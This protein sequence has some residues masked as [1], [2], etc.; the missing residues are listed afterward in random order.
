[1]KRPSKDIIENRKYSLEIRLLMF[2]V[3]IE[4][5]WALINGVLSVVIGMPK[6]TTIMYLILAIFNPVYYFLAEVTGFEKVFINAYF[7][8][9]LLRTPVMWYYAGGIKAAGSILFVC[10][11]IVFVMCMSG[12]SQRIFILLALVTNGVVI[13][14]AGRFMS[15]LTFQLTPQQ[16]AAGN[17]VLGPS[18]S[19][20]IAVLLMKQ[21]YEYVH[22]RDAAIK[23]EKELARSNQ[24]QKIFLANMSHEIRSPLGIVLG[25]NSLISESNDIKQ[26]HEYSGNIEHAGKTLQTVINDILDYS[27][28]ESGKLDIIDVDYSFKE[29]FDEICTDIAFRCEAKGLNF[30]HSADSS[31]P[32]YLKGDDVRI[33]QCMLNVLSNAV[34]YTE[35]GTVYFRARYDGLDENNMHKLSF[36]IK[37]TGKGISKEAI[38]KLFT[39]FQRVDEDH[40][41]GIEGTGLGLAITKSLLDEMNGSIEVES[42]LG[43][44][45]TFK[46]S[47]SQ[48]QSEVKALKKEEEEEISLKNVKVLVCDDTK[49]N[50]VIIQKFLTI[51][52]AEVTLV[53]S[54]Q[55]CLEA[56][57]N[58]KFDI[59]LLDHMMPEMDGIETLNYL[60]ALDCPNKNI[61]VIMLTANAMAGA[62]QDYIRLGFNDYI[63][64]PVDRNKL[65]NSVASFL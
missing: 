27:K 13:S 8:L 50:L 17:S 34:K 61:P 19:I 32:A 49:M 35:Q 55:K 23:S 62:K 43:V 20:L 2:Y 4:E 29:L 56:C 25:F 33:R 36:E 39:A 64:K 38:P 58:E 9:L 37:D 47:I 7:V 45:T 12:T 40:N 44:G 1:M 11:I 59:L 3:I 15:M 41:R 16:S 31:I 53:D 26:I 22:E 30:E 28:I 63:S 52:G 48:S 42:E 6:E 18:T 5:I 14:M 24:L 57:K 65:L 51:S 54:G 10:E 60:R 46:M 21:K